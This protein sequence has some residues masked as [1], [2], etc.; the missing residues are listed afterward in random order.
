M[1]S[2]ALFICNEDPTAGG[3]GGSSVVFNELKAMTQFVAERNDIDE[4]H[5]Y[6]GCESEADIGKLAT[7]GMD[8]NKI[9]LFPFPKEVQT[10]YG[11]DVFAADKWLCER[12]RQGIL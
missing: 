2:I 9:M 3:H 4:I 7:M 8:V 11:A 10:R 6:C 5:V 1:T 12:Y